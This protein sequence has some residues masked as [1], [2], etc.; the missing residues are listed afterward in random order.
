MTL[1]HDTCAALPVPDGPVYRAEIIKDCYPYDPRTEND[2]AAKLYCWHSRYNLGDDNPYNDP[3]ELWCALAE[4]HVP[5]ST[6]R[7][8]I[9]R[10]R[11]NDDLRNDVSYWKILTDDDCKGFLLESWD[12]LDQA[13]RQSI[14]DAIEDVCIVKALYL[15]DHS[16]L[17]ISTGPFSCPWDSGH[18]GYAVM[19]PD[20]IDKEWSGDR[21]SA[22]QCL[23]SEVKVY[24]QYLN[25]DTWGFQITADG[26]LIDSCF[27]FYGS[28]PDEN[29]MLE[30]VDS[31]F[32]A[33]LIE[34]QP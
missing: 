8:L 3:D 29:G 34:A 1:V 21:E 11:W 4:D 27:G 32:H 10:I 13:D 23:E 26:E 7:E 18:V 2:N 33:M 30:H 9:K 20:T 15:Y 14:V 17:S 19:T 31:V 6:F 24:D 5:A 16:G 22:E 12:S 25:G 28:D